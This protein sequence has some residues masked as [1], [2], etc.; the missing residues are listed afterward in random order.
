MT[1][2]QN[3]REVLHYAWSIKCSLIASALC[4]VEFVLPIFFDNPP[5]AAGRF[6]ALAALVSFL[7]AVARI[8]AQAELSGKPNEE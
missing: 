4:A 6:A 3:W 5:I 7:G 8:F 1:R 2:V